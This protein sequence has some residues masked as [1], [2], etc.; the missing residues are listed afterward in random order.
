MARPCGTTREQAT[1]GNEK[2]VGLKSDGFLP[3][4]GQ[5]TASPEPCD[6]AGDD[7]AAARSQQALGSIVP[8]DDLVQT[9]TRR[10][11]GDARPRR[12]V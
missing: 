3:A 1:V 12:T 10:L 5:A 2:E 8:D 4:L 6:G 9:S 7:I 11:R